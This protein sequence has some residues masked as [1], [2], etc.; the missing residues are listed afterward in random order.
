MWLRRQGMTRWRGLKME[1]EEAR[2]ASTIDCHFSQG[3]ARQ[4][5]KGRPHLQRAVCWPAECQASGPILEHSAALAGQ[6]VSVGLGSCWA[7]QPI[8]K[9]SLLAAG[10]MNG[11]WKWSSSQ[12]H[13]QDSPDINLLHWILLKDTQFP[14]QKCCGRERCMSRVLRKSWM[15]ISFWSRR[16]MVSQAESKKSQV[17]VLGC[18]LTVGMECF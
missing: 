17:D 18:S 12:E 3:M 14:Q 1:D 6:E 2:G 16:R 10:S 7:Y 9:A 8:M 5:Y 15:A 4:L 11:L 13:Y